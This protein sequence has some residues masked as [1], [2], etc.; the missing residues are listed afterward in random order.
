VS[1]YYD[2]RQF[3]PAIQVIMLTGESESEVL[4]AIAEEDVCDYV[5]KPV[6]I[7]ELTGKI[8]SALKKAAAIKQMDKH[9]S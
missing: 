4:P 6:D 5:M 3:N 2:Y 7:E 8:D 9:G 1:G